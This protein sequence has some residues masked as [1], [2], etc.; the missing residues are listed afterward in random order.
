M[1]GPGFRAVRSYVNGLG[2][3]WKIAAL[4]ATGCA[5]VAVA[6][7]LLVH[8]A[9]LEQVSAGARAEALAQ[10]VRVRQVY[11]LT[12]QVSQDGIDAR[13]D[14]HDVPRPLERAATAGKRTTY[15]D[16]SSAHPS[17]WAA[18]PIGGHVLSV[19]KPLGEEAAEMGAFD[20]HLLVSGVVVVA[21]AAL[22]LPG[23]SGRSEGAVPP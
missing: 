21:L 2:L 7:G 8:H 4:L 5:L 19:H 18:R 23:G 9:R 12:G 17:V 11:E 15:L 10:L 1:T 3:R 13:L 14:A 6:I 16:L 22:G 20:R